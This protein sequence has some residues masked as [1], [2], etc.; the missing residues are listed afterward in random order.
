MRPSAPSCKDVIANSPSGSCCDSVTSHEA[1]PDM[2]C[3]FRLHGLA[4]LQGRQH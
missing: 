1:R 2:L 3:M 4:A